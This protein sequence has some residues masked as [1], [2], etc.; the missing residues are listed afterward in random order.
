MVDKHYA[1]G[2]G[3][4]CGTC[5]HLG[6]ICRGCGYVEGKPFW[7][8]ELKMELCPL[9]DCCMHKKRL[10]HCGECTELPCE[11]FRN[12]HDPALT[13]QEAQKAVIERQESLLK[14]KEIGT[15]RWLEEKEQ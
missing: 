10:E 13:P 2:C 12:F 6:K 14:R 1:P 9:Y 7:T 11:L 4:Y 3:I 8:A 5:E 15:E